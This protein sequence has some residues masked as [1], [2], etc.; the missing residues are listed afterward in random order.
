VLEVFAAERGLELKRCLS[1]Q[2]LS[3]S[4][5]SLPHAEKAQGAERAGV[6][7]RKG[8]LDAKTWSMK[9]FIMSLQGYPSDMSDAE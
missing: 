8:G 9:E 4:L 2:L 5:R 6:D 3:P 1:R 7:R